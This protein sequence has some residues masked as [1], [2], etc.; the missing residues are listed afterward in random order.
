[1]LLNCGAIDDGGSFSFS[2]DPHLVC[3]CDDKLC[4]HIYTY[5]FSDS[6]SLR[7]LVFAVHLYSFVIYFLINQLLNG[8][9]N[10]N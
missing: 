10:S 4:S 3:A 7:S 8:Y 9:I 6:C 2:Q 1:M 5:F